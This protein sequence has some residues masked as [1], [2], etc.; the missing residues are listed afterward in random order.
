MFV[1]Y[2]SMVFFFLLF[3]AL[4]ILFRTHWVDVL[5]RLISTQMINKKNIF[6]LQIFKK[7]RAKKNLLA[8]NYNAAAWLARGFI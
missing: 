4:F 8:A 3:D 1:I 5:T 7:K 2:H 6:M